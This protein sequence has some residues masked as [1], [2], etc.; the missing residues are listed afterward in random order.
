MSDDQRIRID[1]DAAA[2]LE[3]LTDEGGMSQKALASE[4]IRQFD[5]EGGIEQK[6]AQL[7]R[8]V[9]P[10][11]SDDER[12]LLVGLSEEDPARAWDAYESLLES[13]EKSVSR[14][15]EMW[16]KLQQQ[17]AREAERRAQEPAPDAA[18]MRE[19]LGEVRAVKE[20]L[21]ALGGDDTDGPSP[22]VMALADALQSDPELGDRQGQWI[23]DWFSG[24]DSVTE[25]DIRLAAKKVD[26][27]DKVLDRVLSRY[28]RRLRDE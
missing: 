17:R 18:E 10:T 23:L 20:R 14:A 5:R 16:A 9:V 6:L 25:E 27:P 21:E 12:E 1:S 22:E 4:A 2:R 28:R 26:V 24:G 13:R 3:R 8:A 7:K 15:V 19:K 11:I